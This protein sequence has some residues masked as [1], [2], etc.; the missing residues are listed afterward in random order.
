MYCTWEDNCGE[1]IGLINKYGH[2]L[3]DVSCRNTEGGLFYSPS[4][5]PYVKMSSRWL[6]LCPFL[7]VVLQTSCAELENH[8]TNEEELVGGLVTFVKRT[9]ITTTDQNNI[10]HLMQM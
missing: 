7:I 10:L 6:T 5:L 2:S 3:C 4:Q 9:S 8:D 1:S